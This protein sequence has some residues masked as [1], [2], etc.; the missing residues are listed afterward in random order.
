MRQGRLL[1]KNIVADLRGE[2]AA[3][4]NHKN[5]GAVAGLGV[6]TGVFQSGNFA[7]KGYFA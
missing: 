7:L 1:A 4:Y 3:E 5:A 2:G 6:N